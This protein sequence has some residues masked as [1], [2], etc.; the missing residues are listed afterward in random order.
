MFKKILIA[1]DSDSISMAVRQALDELSVAEFHHVRYCDDA[2]LKIKRAMHDKAPYDLLISDLSFINDRRE[3]RIISGEAL[4]HE[5]RML[6]PSMKIIAF[7]VED[8]PFKIKSLL[9]NAG[10]SGYVFKGRSSITQLKKA[11]VAISNG[12]QYLSP[13]LS[14]IRNDKTI[15]EIDSYDTQLLNLLAQGL[16]QEEIAKQMKEAGITPNSVSAIEKRISRLKIY[17]MAGNNVQ[18]VVKAKDLGFI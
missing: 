11:I 14:H 17:F 5:V 12:D 13:E 9:D 16:K 10:I 2:F 18:I 1:E 7:S 4:M 8:R 15:C 6:Q 3:N